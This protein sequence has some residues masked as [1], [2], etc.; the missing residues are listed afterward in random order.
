MWHSCGGFAYFFKVW[1][2]SWPA[3]FCGET[4]YIYLIRPFDE[5]NLAI[6]ICVSY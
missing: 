5:Q 4:E 2:I 1:H 6:N 3:L